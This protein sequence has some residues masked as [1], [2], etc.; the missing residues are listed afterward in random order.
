M[1]LEGRRLKV[2]RMRDAHRY[3]HG[4][5]TEDSIAKV[6]ITVDGFD[7]ADLVASDLKS[8]QDTFTKSREL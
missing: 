7:E 5:C 4:A 8:V 2:A 1:E 6:S 3:W